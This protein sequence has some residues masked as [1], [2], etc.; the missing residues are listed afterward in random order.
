M[1]FDKNQAIYNVLA[2]IP[3]GKVTTYGR[4]AEFAG[5][6]NAARYVGT[7]LRKLPEDTQLPWHR[8]INGQGKIALPENHPGRQ[9]QIAKLQEE[10]VLVIE[11]KVNLKNYLW[12]P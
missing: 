7:I 8:V 2:S 11:G 3:S 6:K 1:Q 4:V 12:I 9:T 10:G 5:L